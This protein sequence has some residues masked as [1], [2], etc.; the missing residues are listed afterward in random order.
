MVNKTRIFF[1]I[2]IIARQISHDPSPMRE[3]LIL[4]SLNIPRK[5]SQ[6]QKKCR[7]NNFPYRRNYQNYNQLPIKKTGKKNDQKNELQ[8][9]KM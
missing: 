4:L 5:K 7:N 9:K 2:V 1:Y 8:K 3:K 6:F